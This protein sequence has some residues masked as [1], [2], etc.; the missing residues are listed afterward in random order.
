MA[1][2]PRPRRKAS[3]PLSPPQPSWQAL[4][5][6]RLRALLRRYPIDRSS[7]HAPTETM[8]RAELLEALRQI[9]AMGFDG[10]GA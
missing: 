5:V 4:P 2:Q 1:L 8:R 7:L 6:R 9:G 10:E 3:H